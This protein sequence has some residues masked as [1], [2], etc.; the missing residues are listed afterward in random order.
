M[1]VESILLGEIYEAL[2]QTKWNRHG[3]EQKQVRA[4]SDLMSDAKSCYEPI[5][6]R[7]QVRAGMGKR[8][9]AM[10]SRG[11]GGGRGE[12]ARGR[13][14]RRKVSSEKVGRVSWR[15]IEGGE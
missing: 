3:Q 12:G 4:R 7:A 5:Q 11:R 6:E 15:T 1:C 10:G 14:G 9:G 8:E 13:G 2:M